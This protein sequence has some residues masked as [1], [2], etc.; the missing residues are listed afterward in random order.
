MRTGPWCWCGR[1][2]S[3][4]QKYVGLVRMCGQHLA[5]VRGAGADVWTA[6]ITSM[7]GLY[8]CVGAYWYMVLV[9]MCGQHAPQVCGACADVWAPCILV[10]GA[11][12]D[13]WAACHATQVR[14]AAADV[15]AACHVAQVRGAAAD[16]W[17]T[18]GT[19]T[20]GC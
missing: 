2:G 10:H 15:W 7:W 14:A 19:S 6:C 4:R 9:R 13:V 8:G 16:L 20:W 18:C 5:Q 12:V 17:A 11:G 3:M 1:V